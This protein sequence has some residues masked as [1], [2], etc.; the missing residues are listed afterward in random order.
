MLLLRLFPLALKRRLL[1][2]WIRRSHHMF[3]VGT[4]GP[5][6]RRQDSTILSD[7]LIWTIILMTNVL[8]PTQSILPKDNQAAAAAAIHELAAAFSASAAAWWGERGAR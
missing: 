1:R 8:P 6:L 7:I 5:T 2:T 3:T 4:L